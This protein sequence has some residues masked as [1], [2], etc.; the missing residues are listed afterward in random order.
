MAAGTAAR[1]DRSHLS[2]APESPPGVPSV[3]EPSWAAVLANTVRLWAQRRAN[4]LITPGRRRWRMVLLVVLVL[5]VA[6]G[7]LAL[8]ASRHGQTGAAG[9]LSANANPGAAAVTS[10]IAIRGEAAGWV[11]RQVSHTA[12]VACDPVMCAAL[13]SRGFPATNLVPILPT[14]PDPLGAELVVATAALR[15]QFGARLAT[16]YAPQVIAGFGT[17]PDRI[18]IRTIPPGGAAVFRRQFAAAERAARHQGALLL[19][20][21]RIAAS[22]AARA[23]L[24]AGHVD[25]RLL[26][27]LA[28]LAHSH[29]VRIITFGHA[30]PG[31]GPVIPL[32]SVDLAGADQAS[33]LPPAAYRRWLVGFLHAQRSAFLATS[34]TVWTSAGGATVVRI[35]FAAP[36]VLSGPGG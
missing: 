9:S 10:A 1:R 34:V 33:G 29:A 35:E 3:T 22:P 25:A 32:R 4:R 36:S 21:R 16:V 17:G 28:A 6:A 23:A 13:H 14:K 5:A 20:N 11:A 30:D 26:A 2:A 27:T 24:A 7:A 31:A 18:E 8:A 19:G 15:N 12:T